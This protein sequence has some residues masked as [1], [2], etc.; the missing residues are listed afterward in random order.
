[1][2]IYRYNQGMPC[3]EGERVVA[4]GFFDGVHIGHRR[5]LAMGRTEAEARNIPFAVF[6][7]YDSVAIKRDTGRLYSDDEKLFLLQECGV[8]EVIIANFEELK[9]LSPE[10]FVRDLLRKVC[11]ARVAVVGKDFRFGKGA[12]ADAAE[13]SALME[14]CGDKAT[15][16]D[17]VTLF[18]KKVS[19][20]AIKEYLRSG[21][22]VRANEMLGAPYFIM[23]KVEHGRGVGKALGF[24][25][26]NCSLDGR[27]DVLRRGVYRAQLTIDDKTYE[28]LTNIGTC[29][30]FPEREEHAETYILGFDGELY[31][32]GVRINLLNFLRDEI[33]FS[34]ENDLKTQ[35]NIDIQ[36]VK[37]HK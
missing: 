31:G 9:D 23:A 3:L 2:K 26:L 33:R 4:L 7:F 21:D 11:G 10:S 25:T 34:S 18:S 24:P 5:L 37:N 1:M 32:E 12:S 16:I 22:I 15:V 19:A 17:D 36:T 20:S 29:P 27:R 30:T 6:T 14:S 13:L 28:A 8:D 35:I